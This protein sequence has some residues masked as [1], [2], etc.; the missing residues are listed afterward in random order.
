MSNT[1]ANNPQP[2][3]LKSCN[4]CRK[5]HSKCD[6]K[7]PCLSCVLHNMTCEYAFKQ[8]RPRKPPKKEIILQSELLKLKSEY[9][10]LEHSEKYWKEKYEQESEKNKALIAKQE[11]TKVLFDTYGE[12]N[13]FVIYASIYELVQRGG[14][15]K[16]QLP[17]SVSSI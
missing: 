14:V 9:E 6:G 5:T 12:E 8:P 3:R 15:F 4:Y 17:T 11:P 7:Q 16:G 13:M 10:R 1:T 2:E